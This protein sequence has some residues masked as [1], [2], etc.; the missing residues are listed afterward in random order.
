MSSNSIN[1]FNRERAELRQAEGTPVI[2]YQHNRRERRFMGKTEKDF[3][4]FLRSAGLE[5]TTRASFN[6]DHEI[7]KWSVGVFDYDGAQPFLVLQED[8]LSTVAKKIADAG[9]ENY[10][11]IF[12]IL[13]MKIEPEQNYPK[14]LY[15]VKPQPT[16]RR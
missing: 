12:K 6:Y 10:L 7:S 5:T 9:V 1:R 15:V 2:K 11:G 14:N 3:N 16:G 8:D 13:D 4:K